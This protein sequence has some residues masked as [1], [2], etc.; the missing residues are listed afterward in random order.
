MPSPSKQAV[1]EV[2]NLH[3]ELQITAKNGF[4]LGCIPFTAICDEIESLNDRFTGVCNTIVDRISK[5]FK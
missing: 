4:R 2:H 5:F 3:N 1:E